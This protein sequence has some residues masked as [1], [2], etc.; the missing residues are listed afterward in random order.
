MELGGEKWL[1][2]HAYY[3]EQEFWSMHNRKE[4]DDLR[5]KF[6]AS[7]LPSI[8][9]KIKVDIPAELEIKRQTWILW[10]WALIWSIWPLSG[11]YGVLKASLGGDYLLPTNV[12]RCKGK[13]E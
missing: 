10:L 6:H 5:A 4:Y 2:A 13:L 9:D 8:Y 1:Y 7:H 11:V 3:T 12:D